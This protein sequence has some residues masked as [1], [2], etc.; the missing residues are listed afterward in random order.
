MMFKTYSS[1]VR[2]LDIKPPTKTNGRKPLSLKKI[3]AGVL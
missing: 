1:G 2:K 3:L